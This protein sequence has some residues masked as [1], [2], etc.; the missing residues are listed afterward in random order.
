MLL[1]QNSRR[2]FRVLLHSGHE[3]FVS[4]FVDYAE[5]TRGVSPKTLRV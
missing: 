5:F 4:E 3:I 2:E 1:I